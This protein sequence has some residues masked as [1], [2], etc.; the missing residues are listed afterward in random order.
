MENKRRER[1][2]QKIVR[3]LV[4]VFL[5]EE[6]IAERLEEIKKTGESR[7]QYVKRLIREDIKKSQKI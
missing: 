4:E 6:D 5:H 3:F 7:Q 2:N 1:Y